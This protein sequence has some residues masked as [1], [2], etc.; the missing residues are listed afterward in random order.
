MINSMKANDKEGYLF[1]K[2]SYI[3]F[4]DTEIII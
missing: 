3:M 1:F 4:V 2:Y